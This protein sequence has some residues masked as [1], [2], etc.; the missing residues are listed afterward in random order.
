[1]SFPTNRKRIDT[2]DTG[3]VAPKKKVA[4]YSIVEFKNKEAMDAWRKAFDA[5]QE[6]KS[7]QRSQERRQNAI[8]AFGRGMGSWTDKSTHAAISAR[9]AEE[10]A[11]IAVAISPPKSVLQRVSEWF[12]KVWKSAF[13]I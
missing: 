3:I 1:M 8:N 4:P 6:Q 12:G 10:K 2:A 9:K 7:L 13:P 5:E 11:A